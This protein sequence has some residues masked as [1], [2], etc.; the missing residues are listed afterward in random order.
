MLK[1]PIQKCSVSHLIL[2]LN[3]LL[4]YTIKTVKEYPVLSAR[5]LCNK[6]MIKSDRK[7]ELTAALALPNQQKSKAEAKSKSNQYPP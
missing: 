7:S 1:V 5:C 2:Y 4:Q 6:Q 3:H